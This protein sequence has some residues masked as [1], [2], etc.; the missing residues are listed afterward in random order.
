MNYYDAR[1]RQK[2][3]K[4][5]GIFDYTCM[6]DDQIWPVGYCPSCGGHQTQEEAY[7]CYKKYEL[8]HH[9]H[10]DVE[11]HDTQH[12]CEICEG[13]TQKGAEVGHGRLW[14][15]CDAHR[16]RETVEGLFGVGYTISSY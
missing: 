4:G 13:W 8:D 11:S 14:W 10:L 7:E 1:E 12:K 9:L 5:I 6:N 16:N 2:D 15:L 3:G